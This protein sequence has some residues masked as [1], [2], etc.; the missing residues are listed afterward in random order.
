MTAL[1]LILADQL[2]PSIATL[3]GADKSQD[4]ILLCE[5]MEEASYV[6]HHPKK[7]A[8]LFSAMRHFAAALTQAGYRV[9]YVK[10]DDPANTGSFTSEV[11][12]A[13]QEE[14][15]TQ[16]VVTEPAEWRV[17]EM[18]RAWDFIPLSILPDDRFLCSRQE[19]SDWVGE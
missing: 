6:P 4:V 19:F 15:A 8:F 9:R 11:Q 16:L 3:R 1:R 13:V 10:L 12:R 14:A 2:S 7:I 5:V 17:M 18:F